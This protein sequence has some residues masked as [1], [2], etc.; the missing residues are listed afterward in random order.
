MINNEIEE[1]Y[2]QSGYVGNAILWWG[3]ES[4]GYTANFKNAGRYSKD[5]TLAIINN[6]PNE[7]HA[8]LCSYI[9]NCEKAQVLTIDSQYLN[10]DFRILGKK[11]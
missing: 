6:R 10:T 11:K 4:S 3:K 1:Y 2:I 5:K 9:D 7:D 8:W